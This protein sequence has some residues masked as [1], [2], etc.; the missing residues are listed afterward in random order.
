MTNQPIQTMLFSPQVV[1]KTDARKALGC[2]WERTDALALIRPQP[3]VSLNYP[4]HP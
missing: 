3:F 2:G 4:D 1:S